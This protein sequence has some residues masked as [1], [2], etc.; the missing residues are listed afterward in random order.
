LNAKILIVDDDR[1]TIQLLNDALRGLGEVFFATDGLAA[2]RL[3]QEHRPDIVLLDCQIPGLDGFGVCGVLK[4]D[5]A[6]AAA[7]VFFITAHGDIETETRAFELGAADFIQKPISVSVVRARVSYHLVM[8]AQET[9]LKRLVATDPLTGLSNRRALDDILDREWR[10]A[11]R[12]GVPLGM[13]MVD[14]DYFK[15]YNDCYGHPAGDACLKAIAGLLRSNVRRPVDF[16]A[17]YGGEEFAVLLPGT[18]MQGASRVGE[19]LCD[20]VRAKKIIHPKSPLGSFV[21]AS[22]GV[23]A[24]V[25]ERAGAA[26]ALV[27]AADEAL[28]EAKHTGRN[29]VAYRHPSLAETV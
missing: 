12:T 26:S 10:R 15:D 25:P 16:V 2:L 14:L 6:T 24:L 1:A 13:I 18:G 23:A 29:R 8:K 9:E 3:A 20:A 5:P 7:A 11:R 28:Y 22:F 4:A 27:A 21:T 19:L 17:R